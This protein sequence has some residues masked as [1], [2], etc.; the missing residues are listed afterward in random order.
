MRYI[1]YNGEMK[2]AESIDIPVDSHALRYGFGVFETLLVRD[3]VIQLAEYHWDRLVSGMN[4]LGMR[5]NALTFH[6]FYDEI[7][8]C[9]QQNGLKQ[10]ARVRF[11]VFSG[12]GGFSE[13]YATTVN[14]LIECFPID[15]VIFQ[16]NERGLTVGVADGVYKSNDVFANCKTS[17]MLPYLMAAKQAQR[18]QWDDAWVRNVQGRII[19]STI[20]NVFWIKDGSLFTPPL[21]EGCIAGVMRR[22][23]TERCAIEVIERPLTSEMLYDAEEVFLTNSIRGIKWVG[24]SA[25]RSYT[26]EKV[27]EVHQILIKNWSQF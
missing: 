5:P 11:Q 22:F 19:E 20:A 7:V 24:Q 13:K 10:W 15:P 9:V 8:S 12:R 4:I 3:G 25:A 27:R 14:F 6:Q 18:L 2:L 26:C 23:I 1:N 16:L 17:N 21:T